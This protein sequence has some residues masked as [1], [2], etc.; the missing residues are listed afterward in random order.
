MTWGCWLSIST[1]TILKKSQHGTKI[2]SK[3]RCFAAMVSREG[4][5]PVDAPV[6][7]RFLL[8]GLLCCFSYLEERRGGTLKRQNQVAASFKVNSSRD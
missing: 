6:S 1:I 5:S 7:L 2:V 3:K 8:V 4:A